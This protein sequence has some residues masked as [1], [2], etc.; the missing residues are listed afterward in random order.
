MQDAGKA[1]ILTDRNCQKYARAF[2][3]S[4]QGQ[5]FQTAR[6]AIPSGETQKR[7]ANAARLYDRM[8]RMR[9]ERKSLF[10]A[11]GGGMITDLGGFAASTYM[12]GIPLVLASTTLLGQVDAAIGGKTA[13][14]LPQGK[15]LVGTFY[16]PMAV[17]LD[18]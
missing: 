2:E 4:L 9:L 1:F 3:K 10:V 13:V 15:N 17:F 5:G 7:L 11:V 16:Q 8:A 14:N 6:L 12:R 18:S